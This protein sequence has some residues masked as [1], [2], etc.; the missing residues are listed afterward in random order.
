M[1]TVP[2]DTPVT[3]PVEDTVATVG[4][5]L[6]QA[7]PVAVSPRDVVPPTHNVDVPVIVP[8]FGSGL[9]VTVI[10]AVAVPQL[11]LTP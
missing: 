3:T 11:L 8:V 10:I 1:V 5:L 2:V 6:V 7:P 4:L 9:M